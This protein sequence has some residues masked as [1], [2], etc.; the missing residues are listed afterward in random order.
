MV[1]LPVPAGVIAAYSELSDGNMSLTHG[2]TDAGAENR[3]RFCA[4]AGIDIGSLVV[5]RQVH[6]ERIVRVGGEDRAHG[7]LQAQSAVADT[8]AL[9]CNEPGVACCVQTADCLAV[10]LYDPGSRSVGIVH[11]GWRSTR[12][13]LAA[14]TVR[15]MGDAFGAAAQDICAW[16]G[17]CL[18]PCCY[19]VGEEFAGYFPQ[20]VSRGRG[21]LHFDIAAANRRQLLACGV[22]TGQIVSAGPCTACQAQRFFSHRRQAAA[23]GRMLSVIQIAR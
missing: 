10:F 7:A 3:R 22:P 4:A 11:A 18:G 12:L 16:F 13:Q 9:I 17:P 20:E 5:P 8:D 2:A 23:A 19:E 6:G 1:R 14:K 15:M 21:T